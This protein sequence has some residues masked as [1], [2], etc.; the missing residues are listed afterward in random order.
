MALQRHTFIALNSTFIVDAEYEYV[1]DL[2]KGIYGCV[3][4]TKHRSS[5][6]GFAIKKI[7]NI[8]TKGIL[9]K[10]CLQE[11]KLL[12]YFRGHKNIICLYNMDIVFGP[13]G[14]F[15]EV[16]LYQEVMEADLHAII[17]SGQPLTD[18][19]YQSFIYQTICRLKYIHSAN[20]LHRDLKPSNLLVNA[21]REL[22]IQWTWLPKSNKTHV[23]LVM[24]F[25]KDSAVAEGEN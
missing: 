25:G 19:H 24:V 9:T 20:V 1:K 4:A 16:Y 5:G 13:K 8:N 7:T 23:Q 21:D 3:V 2:R 22:K 17:L 18:A 15:G 10:R 6:K 11:I 14:E 12:H